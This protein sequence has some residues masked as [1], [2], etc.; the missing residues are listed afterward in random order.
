MSFSSKT[1]HR[2]I[3]CDDVGPREMRFCRETSASQPVKMMAFVMDSV[4]SAA[5]VGGL[6]GGVVQ[7]SWASVS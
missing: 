6:L 5:L 2:V 1:C 7:S 3:V 4:D